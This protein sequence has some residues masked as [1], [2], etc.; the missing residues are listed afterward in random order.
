MPAF[1]LAIAATAAVIV[2]GSYFFGGKD[3][4]PAPPSGSGTQPPRP[5]PRARTST[6]PDY[7]WDVP[8]VQTPTRTKL[9]STRSDERASIEDAI[10]LRE[11]ARR[12]GNEM[13]EA[14][15]RAKVAQKKGLRGAAQE[16]RQRADARKSEM[17]ELNKRAAKIFFREKN[18]NRKE[19][20][21]IDLHYLFV[22]EAI[23]FAKEELRSA[24]S[25]GDAAVRF[26]VGKGL[27]AEDGVA[28]IRP[29]LEDLCTKRGLGHSLDPKNAGVLVVRLD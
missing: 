13:S 28:K 1:V 4:G 7:G 23:G 19:G 22:A 6:S 29:A 26:I 15:S 25:R 11:Q 16:H 20:G 18:K 27:H 10:K 17:E 9:S 24:S 5:P 14:Y 12:S 3:D 21:M 2:L 8:H